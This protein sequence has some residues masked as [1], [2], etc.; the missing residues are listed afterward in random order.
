MPYLVPL[1]A[2]SLFLNWVAETSVTHWGWLALSSYPQQQLAGQLKS[3]TKVNLHGEKDVFFRFWNGDYLSSVL[4]SS[5]AEQQRDLMQGFASIWTCKTAIDLPSCTEIHPVT[6]PV[7]LTLTL[8][9]LNSL[10]QQKQSQRWQMLRDYFVQRYPKRS[11]S[12]GEQQT[13]LFITLMLDNSGK[14]GITRNDQTRQYLDLALMLGSYFDS[15]PMLA[16]WANV[17][18]KNAAED[19]TSLDLLRDDLAPALQKSMGNDLSV[20]LMRLND[21][22]GRD[23]DN[24]TVITHEADIP[25]VVRGYYPERHEQLAEGT[26]QRLYHNSLPLYYQF[27]FFNLTSHSILLSLQLFL[28]YQVFSDPLYPWVTNLVTEKERVAENNRLRELLSYAKKR[29]NKEIVMVNK[30]LEK[31]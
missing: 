13:Q 6:S 10:Y 7:T 3:M 22:A 28:G 19:V 5:T 26:L 16:P 23:V 4:M 12:L 29:I 27:G 15:D 18:L 25:N 14:Y 11:R 20:Y 31:K 8:T 17:R 30:S 24:L 1:R 9:Q 2:D 21:L